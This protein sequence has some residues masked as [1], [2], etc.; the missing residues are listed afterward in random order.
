MSEK[1]YNV[2]VLEPGKDWRTLTSW[3]TQ[4]LAV[5]D[6]RAVCEESDGRRFPF[7]TQCRVRV[8]VGGRAVEWVEGPVSRSTVFDVAPEKRHRDLGE[9]VSQPLDGGVANL[10]SGSSEEPCNGAV[11]EPVRVHVDMDARRAAVR[12]L[13]HATVAL[14]RSELRIVR[15]AEQAKVASQ[16][17]RDADSA[18]DAAH[19]AK[20]A[21]QHTYNDARDLILG[22]LIGDAK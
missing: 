5:T 19:D 9:Y 10:Q 14:I 12:T 7:G 4:D 17:A 11:L 2:M 20:D 21:A 22:F 15:A 13:E 8:Y 3:E 16:A 6:M 18:L 1:R